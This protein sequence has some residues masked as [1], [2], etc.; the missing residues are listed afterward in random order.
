LVIPPEKRPHPRRMRLVKGRRGRKKLRVAPSPP[1]KHL[2]EISEAYNYN[3]RV[4]RGT[5]QDLQRL[6][7]ISTTFLPLAFITGLYGMN[8][9]DM[10]ELHFHYT[11]FVVLSILVVLFVASFYYLRRKR[12]L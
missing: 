8:F 11:Y 9:E 5:N 10:P 3:T 7:D 12:M 6:T 1:T 2:A 4:T